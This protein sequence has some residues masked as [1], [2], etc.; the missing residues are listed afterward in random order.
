[1]KKL[2]ITMLIG[3]AVVTMGLT[4]T[5]FTESWR[6]ALPAALHTLVGGYKDAAP[7]SFILLLPIASVAVFL[8]ADIIISLITR[9]CS[10]KKPAEH[11][12]TTSFFRR[13]SFVCPIA[14]FLIFIAV[15]LF[16]NPFSLCMPDGDYVVVMTIIYW[17]AFLYSIILTS[18]WVG[19]AATWKVNKIA[20]S[21]LWTICA[22]ALLFFLFFGWFWK[23]VGPDCSKYRIQSTT[24]E[25]TSPAKPV[26][27]A[28][29]EA[30]ANFSPD[31]DEMDF[32]ETDR[33]SQVWSATSETAVD[34]VK[35]ALWYCLNYDNDYGNRYIPTFLALDYPHILSDTPLSY[36]DRSWSWQEH[37]G[38]M[39]LYDV[40]Q[41]LKG[42]NSRLLATYKTYNYLIFNYLSDKKYKSSGLGDMIEEF[43]HAYADIFRNGKAE[44][45]E[46]L[47]RIYQHLAISNHVELEDYYDSLVD[48]VSSDVLP[49]FS[50]DGEIDR[51]GVVYAYGFWA[52]RHHDGTIDATHTIMERIRSYYKV[53]D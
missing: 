3:G 9:L 49:F 31:A 27:S 14:A 17:L 39:K 1:M 40:G 22:I 36:G 33:L 44:A 2:G 8:L 46:R 10:K 21:V 20:S 12:K 23:E 37:Q 53:T 41:F 7:L 45:A 16:K 26:P 34:N 5:A 15:A 48:D 42:S 35:S 24:V 43:E 25:P 51:R 19:A 11:Q 52:R 28:V 6:S 38:Y 30:I 50:Y 29:L 18:L 13:Y 32:P 47:E 4:A